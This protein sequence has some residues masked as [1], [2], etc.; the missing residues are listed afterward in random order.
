MPH[1]GRL[2]EANACVKQ[3]LAC[4]HGGTLWLD[5]PIE[6]TVDLIAEITGLPKDGIDPSQYFKGQDN[7]K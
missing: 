4:F 3:L 5:T 6:V 2:N 7:D 1:F